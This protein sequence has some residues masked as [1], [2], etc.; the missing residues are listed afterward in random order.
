VATRPVRADEAPV[1][2]RVPFAP[3]SVG[4]A[5]QQLRAWMAAHGCSRD[6]IEDARVVM[7]ELVANSVRHA[8]PLPDGNIV[9][10]WCVER[11]GLDVAVTDG[12][13]S[14]HPRKVNAPSSA[15]AGRGMAIVD[16]LAMSWW[17]ERT[18]SRSTVHALLPMP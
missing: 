11:R 3:S 8:N 16:S 1:T 2:L 5:R 18:R 13:G 4:V 10:S 7:S 6:H 17:A 15:V 9:V 12:G 14:T